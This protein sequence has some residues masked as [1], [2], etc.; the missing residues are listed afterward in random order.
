LR[1]VREACQLP[2][3]QARTARELCVVLCIGVVGQGGP[4]LVL[5][6]SCRKKWLV[7]ESA[8]EKVVEWELG[9]QEPVGLLVPP[10]IVALSWVGTW[11]S[12][13]VMVVALVLRSE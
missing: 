2:V 1:R 6:R 7:P 8:L 9:V 5:L 13:V 4:L 3:R 11:P 12:V 10:R